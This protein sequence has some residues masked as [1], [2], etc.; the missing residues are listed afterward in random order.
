MTRPELPPI[1]VLLV[2]DDAGDAVLVEEHFARCSIAVALH[3]VTSLAEALETRRIRID[4]VLL[5]LALP[6]AR[7]LEALTAVLAAFDAPVVVLT[8]FSDHELG[9]AAVAAGAED[10]LAK[11]EVDPALLERSVRYAI[12]R[13]RTKD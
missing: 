4:C 11:N 9:V 13:H 6:D 3:H 8:G 5:D 1:Q 10:Y 12:E 7:D 2:E